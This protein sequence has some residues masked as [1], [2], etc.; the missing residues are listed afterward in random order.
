MDQTNGR[1]CGRRRPGIAALLLALALGADSTGATTMTPLATAANPTS[2]GVAT[3]A[4][5]PTV[6]VL[7]TGTTSARTATPLPSAR[8]TPVTSSDP[9]DGTE[10]LP[11]AEE[12]APV[13]IATS[14]AARPRAFR[15]PERA[16]PPAF[17]A[18]QAAMPPAE[19]EPRPEPPGVGSPPSRST[20]ALVV[21]RAT[22]RTA[23][24]G[25][26][27][28]VGYPRPLGTFAGNGHQADCSAGTGAMVVASDRGDG[29]LRLIVASAQALPFPL[30]V[31][32]RFALAPGAG[33]DAA[34]FDVRIAEVTRDA[35]GA[36]PSLL[37]VDVVVR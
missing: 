13:P 15:T 17:V 32:C 22:A 29:Q 35:K 16:A 36:D 31:F 25:F 37:I 30:D 21:F 6:G 2:T 27:L 8:P 14:L 7:I 20:A 33:I 19:A 23:L 26:D 24:E 10:P 1:P 3:P 4:A 11:P 18:P 28:R 9:G 5:T 12:A 34:A